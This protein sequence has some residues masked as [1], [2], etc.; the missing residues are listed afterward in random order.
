[1]TSFGEN[2][3]FFALTSITRGPSDAI[4][5]RAKLATLVRIAIASAPTTAMSE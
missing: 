3:N 2:S 4:A 5:G 1:V